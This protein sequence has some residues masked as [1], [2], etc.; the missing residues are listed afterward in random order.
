MTVARHEG[1][2]QLCCDGCPASFPETYEAED[3][4]T[5][6]ADAR[7]A[8]WRIVKRQ[9]PAEP[10]TRGLFGRA[11]RIAGPRRKPEP[12][13]HTCPACLA[14]AEPHGSLL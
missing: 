12:Y 4:A 2:L 1:R 9:L 11:P 13:S 3:F 8:G 10:D 5:M 14:P 7:A 6:I